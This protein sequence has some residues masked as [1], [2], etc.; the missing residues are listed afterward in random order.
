[1]SGA[2]KA[3]EY[4]QHATVEEEVCAGSKCVHGASE[5]L[6]A[7]AIK[8]KQHNQTGFDRSASVNL[9]VVLQNFNSLLK[10]LSFI[11]VS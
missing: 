4:H 5:C 6:T 10:L 11:T 9:L 3:K 8:D 7:D 1:M 2:Y